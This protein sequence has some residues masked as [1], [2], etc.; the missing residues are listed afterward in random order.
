MIDRV[1]SA[2]GVDI[3]YG[4]S[5]SGPPLVLVHGT[6]SERKRWQP[7]LADFEKSYTVHA[8]DRRGRG[9][10]GDSTEYSFEA[11][12]A[13]VAAV[14]DSIGNDEVRLVA[15]SYGAICALEATRRTSKVY[16]LVVYEP[17]IRFG[18][19]KPDPVEDRYLADQTER[20]ARGDRVGVLEAFYRRRSIQ[21][22]VLERFRIQANWPDRMA[23][24]HTLVRENEAVKGY[25]FDTEAFRKLTVPTLLI[26]GGDSV[27]LHHIAAAALQETL[28]NSSRVVLDG[29]QHD[30]IDTDTERFAREVLRFL[31]D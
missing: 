1:R 21:P 17:P 28:P 12:F 13:D 23:T 27:P 16:K 5:G 18:E 3:A 4:K 2:D 24:A 11:E 7:V 31:A 14:I 15:H 10:S 26:L 30:A 25:Q 19:R 6:S 22:E 8:I 29:Q 20:L 9:D